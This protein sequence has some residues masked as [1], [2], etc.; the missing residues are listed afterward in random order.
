MIPHFQ[1]QLFTIIRLSL[2]AIPPQLLPSYDLDFSSVIIP[3]QDFVS[4][5]HSLDLD[6]A[7]VQL[8]IN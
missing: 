4:V 8:L 2:V 1:V 3:D 6:F 7:S 5:R